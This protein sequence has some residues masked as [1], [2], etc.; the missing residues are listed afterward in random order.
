MRAPILRL[1]EHELVTD[2]FAGGGG[3]SLGI[4]WALGRS[5]DIAVNHD[6]EAI[7]MHAANHPRTKHLCGDVWDVDPEAVCG[8]RRVGLAWFSPDCTFF[9]KAKGGKPRSAKRRALA[10]VV[11]RWART[12]RPRV[13]VLE[14]VEEFASWGPLLHDGTPCPK[15]KGLTFRVWLGKL[16]AAGY[17]VEMRELRACDYGAPTTRK[18]LFVI[19]RCDGQPIVWPEP[20]HGKHRQPYR[21][22]AE[23]IE[24]SI[25]CPSIFDRKKP[26]AEATLRRIARGIQ[27]YVL[28]NADPFIIPV[29]HA[30]DER[31]H[32]IDEPVRTITASSRSPFAL[33]A[34]TLVQTGYGEREGQAPRAL[35]LHKPLGTIVACG[36]KHGLVSAFLAKH[37]GGVVGQGLR[38][39]IGTVTTRDHHALVT[40]R[41]GG[42][43]VERVRAFLTR[44]NGQGLGQP[45][46][47][48]LGTVTTRDRFGLVTVAGEDYALSDIGMR[49]LQP[50]ELFRAQGFP[51]SF[52]IAPV[53]NGKPLTLSAQIRMCGNS[54]SPFVACAIVKANVGGEKEV[55]AA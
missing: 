30:G 12:V 54:V 13:I 53:V 29:S 43:G 7:A 18:R 26:L 38:V 3:A 23:C 8:G 47:L 41:A 51:D 4:E 24:W 36:Q 22:A 5:P 55:A 21:T 42:D 15:R 33:V 28:D 31:V 17:E 2:C 37:Y 40:A 25:A 48:P 34:P 16:K 46:Q 6:P 32:A 1:H 44:Y 11:V 39:P 49:M 52:E 50:R 14:N 19:A 45:A 27:R 20:T 35:D 10:W 9:S